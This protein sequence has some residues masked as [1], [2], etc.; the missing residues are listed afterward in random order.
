M[1]EIIVASQQNK[2]VD[3]L[4]WSDCIEVGE[5]RD[6]MSESTIVFSQGHTKFLIPKN[7]TR[8]QGSWHEASKIYAT[9][10]TLT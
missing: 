7:T 6:A 8:Q 1:Y 4:F 2:C 5:N 9:N 3:G 10:A